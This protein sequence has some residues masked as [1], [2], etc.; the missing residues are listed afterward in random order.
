MCTYKTH[1]H[2]YIHTHVTAYTIDCHI[3]SIRTLTMSESTEKAATRSDA[4]E[5]VTEE[6]KDVKLEEESPS[7][8]PEEVETGDS[9]VPGGEEGEK[10]EGQGPT[11]SDTVDLS[12]R[13]DL[14]GYYEHD[15]SENFENFLAANGGCYILY[16]LILIVMLISIIMICCV[17]KGGVYAVLLVTILAASGRIHLCKH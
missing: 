8:S 7:A 13:P 10:G 14:S 16:M 2:I 12:G 11:P 6:L 15:H 4:A 17:K 1:T 5:E 3:V 9:P